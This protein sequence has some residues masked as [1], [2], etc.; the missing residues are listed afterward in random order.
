V[1]QNNFRVGTAALPESI[2][3]A[4]TGFKR[5][6]LPLAHNRAVTAAILK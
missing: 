3:N 4:L 5:L 2:T 6:S 1:P